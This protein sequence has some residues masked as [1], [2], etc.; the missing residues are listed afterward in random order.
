MHTFLST[1][2]HTH[3]EPKIWARLVS[4]LWSVLSVSSGTDTHRDVQRV[5]GGCAGAPERCREVFVFVFGLLM[6]RSLNTVYWLFWRQFLIL[7]AGK[8]TLDRKA[9]NLKKEKNRWKEQLRYQRD[10]NGSK[11]TF[12]DPILESK[13]RRFISLKIHFSEIR[14]IRER[15]EKWFHM[16]LIPF[17][18]RK[19]KFE[20]FIKSDLE[21]SDSDAELFTV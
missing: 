11:Q 14:R 19:W 20:I 5:N 18:A 4:G 1:W 12:L 2:I 6:Q 10:V 9:R 3:S 8:A 15:F 13:N 16:F 21:T 17:E 7:S